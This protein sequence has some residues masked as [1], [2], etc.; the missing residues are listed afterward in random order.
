MEDHLQDLQERTV[1]LTKTNDQLQEEITNR[2]HSE[3]ALKES[4]ESY[5]YLVENANDIIYRIDLKGYFIFSNPIAVKKTGY[6]RRDLMG[7][8]YFEV[9]RHDYHEDPQKFYISQYMIKFPRT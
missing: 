9:K 1:E 7:M 3:A 6:S 4:E 8:N 2:K 5:R